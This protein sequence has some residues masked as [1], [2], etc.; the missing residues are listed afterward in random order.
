MS[1]DSATLAGPSGQ[2]IPGNN[3]QSILVA[4]GHDSFHILELEMG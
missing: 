1:N 3:L 2:V 4:I